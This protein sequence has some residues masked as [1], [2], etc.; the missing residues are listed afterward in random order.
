MAAN[1]LKKINAEI[2]KLKK[3]HPN[4]S[5]RALQKQASAKYRAGKLGGKSKRHTT[6]KKSVGRVHHKPRKRVG[7]APR[8]NGADRNDS[9]RVSINVGSVSSH[10][11]AAKKKLVDEIGWNEATKLTAKTAK[12]KRMIQKRI[13]EKKARLR[14]LM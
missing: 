13:N 8:S 5:H 14:K 11:N 6:K 12:S 2:K 1:A 7:A 3:K 9:K 10:I 4:S